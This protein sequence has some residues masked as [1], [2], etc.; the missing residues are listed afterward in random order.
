MTRA[1]DTD[2]GTETR[3][4]WVLPAA[5]LLVGLAAGGDWLWPSWGI[6][7]LLVTLGAAASLVKR[8]E[9]AY[10]AVVILLS[11]L[12]GQTI[13]MWLVR[14]PA[15]VAYLERPDHALWVL[16]GTRLLLVSAGMLLA[17]KASGLKIGPGCPPGLW[18]ILVPVSYLLMRLWYVR[19]FFPRLG[20]FAHGWYL[21]E[22]PVVLMLGTAL[23]SSLARATL[24]EI[25]FRGWI[26][27]GLRDH[28][29]PAALWSQAFLFGGLYYHPVLQPYGVTGFLMMFLVGLGL[30]WLRLQTGGVALGIAV[31]VALNLAVFWI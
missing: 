21:E 31:L 5:S 27:A 18:W 28:G 14:Q 4:V 16:S 3:S 6:I 7:A 2:K 13:G 25:T 9:R 15:L 10:G 22:G 24:D 1:R 17:G 23:L 11:F 19:V 30:G 8:W 12:L 26:L 29:A 20:I